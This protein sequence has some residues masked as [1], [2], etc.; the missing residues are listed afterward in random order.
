M[1]GMTSSSEMVGNFLT[2]LPHLMAAFDT[3][4]AFI[5]FSFMA[6]S[7]YQFVLV[8][9]KN[10]R[11]LLIGN[12]GKTSALMVPVMTL[13]VGVMMWNRYLTASLVLSTWFGDGMT[14]NNLLDYPGSGVNEEFDRLIQA[15]SLCFRLFGY[16]LFFIKGWMRLRHLGEDGAF[17]EGGAGVIFGCLLINNVQCI[18]GLSTLFGFGSII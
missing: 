15:V 7:L 17:K 12:R 16:Y 14:P 3:V 11:G 9:D 2:Q 5:G 4:I 1:S 6:F 18:N 8:G 13:F 10:K